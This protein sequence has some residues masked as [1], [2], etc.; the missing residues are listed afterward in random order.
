MQD[1]AQYPQHKRRKQTKPY[2]SCTTNAWVVQEGRDNHQR[3]L[4]RRSAPFRQI[5]YRPLF[6]KGADLCQFAPSAARVIEEV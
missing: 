1:V 4:D 5:M 2:W 6:K 3:D